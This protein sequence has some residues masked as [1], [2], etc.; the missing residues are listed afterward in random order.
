MEIHRL[1]NNFYY[2]SFDA[3]VDQPTL[4]YYVGTRKQLLFDAGNSPKHVNEFLNHLKIYGVGNP[5]A[6][7]I[8]H[9]HWDH[10]FGLSALS[11][12][13]YACRKTKRR[14]KNMQSWAWTKDA[15][16]VRLAKGQESL[17]SH[18]NIQKEYPDLSE[19]KVCLPTNVFSFDK[20][21]DL[22]D[23]KCKLIHV[24]SPH[25]TDCVIFYLPEDKIVFL[26]DAYCSV[27]VGEDW[28]Y[29]KRKLKKFISILEVFPKDTLCIKGHHEPQMVLDLMQELR[30]ELEK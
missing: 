26:G 19:I 15:M 1:G 22:G 24:E 23:R 11:C 7:C 20:V 9:S 16:E 6:V 29:D 3:E 2:S 4:G 27:P 25:D 12:P 8:T 10:T 14:L 13:S 30:Q 18:R 21:I 28:V 5:D 17:F